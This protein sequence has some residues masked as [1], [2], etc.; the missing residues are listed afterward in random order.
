MTSV[1]RSVLKAILK[2]K[3]ISELKKE[4]RM[5]RTYFMHKAK[6]SAVEKFKIENI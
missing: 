1:Y 5:V 6:L 3:C 4:K 2:N